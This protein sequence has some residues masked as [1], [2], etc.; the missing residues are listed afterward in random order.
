[1]A[2]QFEIVLSEPF[3]GRLGFLTQNSMRLVRT[4]PHVIDLGETN[5]LH[6]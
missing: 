5:D 4:F 2:P 1:M 6:L 3:W